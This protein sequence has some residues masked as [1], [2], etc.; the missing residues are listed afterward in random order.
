M[1]EIS[2][3]LNALPLEQDR[4]S[5]I[6]AHTVKGKGVRFMEDR[7][8]WHYKSPSGRRCGMALEELGVPA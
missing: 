7:L 8:I 4:P 2:T 3:T 5:V 1:E 6:I